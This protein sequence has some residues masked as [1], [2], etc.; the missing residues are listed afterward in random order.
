MGKPD[1]VTGKMLAPDGEE[2]KFKSIL[3]AAWWC[4]VTMTTVGYG[5]MYPKTPEGMAIAILAM[6]I[7]LFV[8]ALPVIIVGG[9]FEEA[10]NDFRKEH[11]RR[12]RRLK[13]EEENRS[14]ALVENYLKQINDRIDV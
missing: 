14:G 12:H 10:Y 8:I 1:K 5:D 13:N 7:G 11:K 3:H 6:F 9:K 2:T 4:I